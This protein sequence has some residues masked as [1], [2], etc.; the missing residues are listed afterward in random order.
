MPGAV[1]DDT[2]FFPGFPS[3]DPS[4]KQRKQNLESARALLKA[5]GQENLKFTIATHNQSRRPGLRGRSSG[6]PGDRQG[7]TSA[8]TS[9]PHDDYYSAVGG[10]TT[11]ARRRG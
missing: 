9:S 3:T 7:S 2:P 11:T 8:S 1:G 6:L 4:I 5:A 10:V